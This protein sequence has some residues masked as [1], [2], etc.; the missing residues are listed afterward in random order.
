MHIVLLAVAAAAFSGVIAMAWAGKLGLMAIGLLLVS[1]ATFFVGRRSVHGQARKRLDL[2]AKVL[3]TIGG[4]MSLLRHPIEMENGEK[5]PLFQ[6]ISTYIDQ[7]DPQTFFLWACVAMLVKFVSVI[8][9][10]YGWNLLLRG[11]GIRLPFW[12]TI[13]TSFL[14]GRFIG[15]FLPSTIG[16]DGYTL[17]EAARYT[18]ET[19]RVV[20]A[21]TLEKFIGLTGLLLGIVLTLPISYSVV[22]SAAVGLGSPETAPVLAGILLGVS[23]G[24]TT[25]V[26]LMLVRPKLMVSIV[27]WFASKLGGV[28][29]VQN[30]VG[31]FADA[32]GAYEGQLSLLFST[33]FA[34]YVSHFLT[35]TVYVFTGLALGVTTM[36]FWPVIFG[37]TIQIL[38]TVMSPTIAGEG[39]RELFQALLLSDQYGG[40]A[41]SVLAAALG[42]ISAEAATMWGGAFLWTRTPSW[43]PTFCE[44]D[45]KQVDYAWI[46]ADDEGFSADK[47]QELRRGNGS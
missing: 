25:F 14:I 40:V 1:F 7:V 10:A 19:P 44:V 32:V 27:N 31:K 4:V 43:R 37:S 13:M 3:F 11:Q 26:V 24:I 46:Q 8:A 36:E 23:G 21:K 42:F 9:S 33:L 5:A 39:A 18:N 41:Q 15:T 30:I 2:V 47:V 28:P 35:A 17:Y 6:A 22:K 45:G 29:K 20:T 16:L 34:K 12:Q 38:G